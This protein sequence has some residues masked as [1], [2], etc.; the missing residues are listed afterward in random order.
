LAFAMALVLD[1]GR[2]L[3]DLDGPLRQRVVEVCRQVA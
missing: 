1:I 3:R 2:H